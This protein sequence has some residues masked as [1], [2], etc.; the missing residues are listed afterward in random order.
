MYS[1]IEIKKIKSAEK[2][3]CH[4]AYVMSKHHGRIK[5][6]ALLISLLVRYIQ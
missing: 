4:A 2:L 1:I 3:L 6:V 5:R